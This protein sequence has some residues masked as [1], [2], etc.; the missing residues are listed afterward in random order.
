[1]HQS[2]ANSIDVLNQLG[3]TPWQHSSHLN[4]FNLSER[5]TDVLWI[6][7]W[8]GPKAGLGAVEKKFCE[9]DM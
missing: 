9:L 2:V 1:M 8:V 5:D 4:H 6:G 7:G 3:T